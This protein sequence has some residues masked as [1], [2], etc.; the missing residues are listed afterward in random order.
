MVEADRILL[1][2]DNHTFAKHFSRRLAQYGSVRIAGTKSDALK[3]LADGRSWRAII[4]DLCLPDGRGTD[5]IVEAKRSHPATP[6]LLVTGNPDLC[7][8]NTAYAIDVDYLE[9]PDHLAC[10]ERFMFSRAPL[11]EKIDRQ[12][13][14][15]RE[16]YLLTEA[17]ADV[18]RRSAHGESRDAI[19]SA[20]GAMLATVKRQIW[21]LMQKTADES[22]H[23]AVERLIR[24]IAA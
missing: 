12:A 10:L 21:T 5:V 11:S 4:V 15:W 14:V 6:M 13:R 17:E 22:L 2:D 3:E 24:E 20:R 1:V 18:V 8:V 7:R 19:A 9:K 23:S 16:R